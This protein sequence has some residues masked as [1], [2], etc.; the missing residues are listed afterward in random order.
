MKT[1]I[2]E[3]VNLQCHWLKA[4]KLAMKINYTSYDYL[5]KYF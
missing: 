1:F 3:L 4:G 2:Q 5:R